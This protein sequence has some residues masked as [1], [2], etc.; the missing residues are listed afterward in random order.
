MLVLESTDLIEV[1]TST[2]NALDVAGFYADNTAA[3]FTP[4]KQV[5]TI[6][7]IATTTVIG[8]PAAATTRN[9]SNL[10]FFARGGANTLTVRFNNGAAFVLVLVALASGE[11]LEYENGAGWRVLDPSGQFKQSIAAGAGS[12]ALTSLA[13]QAANTIVA[14]ATAGV[15][16]PTAVAVSAQGVLLRAAGN[17]TDTTAAASTALTRGAAGNLGFQALELATLATQAANSAVANATAGVASPTAI[18]A[19]ASTALCRGAAGN[20]AFQALEI[21]T[22]ASQA[23]N[24]V[25]ANATGGAAVMTAVAIAAQSLLARAAGNL[26]AL[27]ATAAQ[28]LGRNLTGDLSFQLKGLVASNTTMPAATNATTNLTCG[29]SFSIPANTLEA[30][31]VYRVTGEWH[32]VHTAA[33]TPTITIEFL[34]NAVV[35]AA[36]TRVITPIATAA[37]YTGTLIATL[38]CQT[39]GAGGTCVVNLDSKD[40]V[41]TFARGSIEN[42]PNTA[43]PATTA[44]DTTVARTIELRIRMTTAVA[45][46]T[47]TVVHGYIEKL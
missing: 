34:I 32:Y 14:N 44:I 31:A 42:T 30:G 36:V 26:V 25:L 16:S 40:S 45:A 35:I 9:V 22:L 46:N 1:L 28:F 18:T 15:A 6:A 17:L 10:G 7:A 27:T 41:Q 39:T 19:A 23:A 29:G 3:A 24:T 21:A 5:T 20:I 43:A 37:N 12:I 4:D 33:A 11:R 2:A 47:L 13:T 38:R 8:A